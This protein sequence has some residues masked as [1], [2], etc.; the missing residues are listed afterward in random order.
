MATTTCSDAVASLAHM[1][2]EP[3]VGGSEFVPSF[4][5]ALL[6]AVCAAVFILLPYTT[7]YR[8]GDS[9]TVCPPAI[10]WI[11]RTSPDPS[12][13]REER[14]LFPSCRSAALGRLMGSEIVAGLAWFNA[15]LR[16]RPTWRRRRQAVILIRGVAI[17]AGLAAINAVW[18]AIAT[19]RNPHTDFMQ[20]ATAFLAMMS[21]VAAIAHGWLT[22]ALRRAARSVERPAP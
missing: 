18:F 12:A 1:T 5:V 17:F 7:S 15:G 14:H 19:L 13:S 21:A 16:A 4:A 20:R 22:V 3:R 10:T 8:R 6:V 2:D 11:W 9:S